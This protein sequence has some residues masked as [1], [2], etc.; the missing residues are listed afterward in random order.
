MAL[1][2]SYGKFIGQTRR[3]T[4]AESFSF[5]EVIDQSDEEVPRHTHEDAHFCMVIEGAYITSARKVERICSPAT[6][7]FNPEGTTHQDRFYSRGGRFFTVSIASER[8]K[9]VRA[10]LSLID[11]ATGLS[12]PQ[13]SWLAT[14]LYRESK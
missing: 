13:A 9:Q 8:L 2:L 3:E 6:L 1:R 5:A 10:G 4:R 12:S 7:L 14:R 11:H